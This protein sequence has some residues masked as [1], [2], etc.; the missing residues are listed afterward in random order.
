MTIDEIKNHAYKYAHETAGAMHSVSNAYARHYGAIA[1]G[2][3][4]ERYWPSHR[5]E[6]WRWIKHQP[7][8]EWRR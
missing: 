2:E 3:E 5:E 4:N 8:N 6:F 1:E 7:I